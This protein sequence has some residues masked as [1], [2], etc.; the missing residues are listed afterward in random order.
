MKKVYFSIRYRSVHNI[1]SLESFSQSRD[2]YAKQIR[3]IIWVVFQFVYLRAYMSIPEVLG[4]LKAFIT[5]RVCAFQKSDMCQIT[6]LELDSWM[7]QDTWNIIITLF[8]LSGSISNYLLVNIEHLSSGSILNI[9]ASA[10]STT[11]ASTSDISWALHHR[12]S[13]AR[14][15]QTLSPRQHRTSHPRH[16]HT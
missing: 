15:D 5:L 1:K 8:R 9:S 16:H 14:Q 6:S 12:I 2:H 13:S 11:S 4:H 7:S 3:L 10:L